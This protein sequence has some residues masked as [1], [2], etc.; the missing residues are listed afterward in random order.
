MIVGS[1]L[2]SRFFWRSLDVLGFSDP[3]S[4]AASHSKKFKN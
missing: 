1:C 4:S 3:R 2:D